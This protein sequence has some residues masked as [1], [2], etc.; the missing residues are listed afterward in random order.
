MSSGIG[1]GIVVGGRIHRG[2]AGTAGEIGHVL[3]DPDG[4]V[5]RCGNRGCLET[6][7]AGPGLLEQLR[8]THGGGLSLA[9][10]ISL[11]HDGDPVC[12]RVI[13]DAGRWIGLTVAGLCNLLNPGMVVV[14]GELS[15]AGELLLEPLRASVRGHAIPAAGEDIQVVAGELGERAE[16][17]GALALAI[18][19]SDRVLSSRM[20][21][22]AAHA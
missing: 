8:R 7:A 16:V 3:V 19:E 10:V 15:A 17:L 20:V 22:G 1:A 18:G 5:C 21:E 4:H 12:A 6:L 9:D 2:F 11:A 14:G 13:A